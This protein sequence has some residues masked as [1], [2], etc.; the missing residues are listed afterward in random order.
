ME[1]TIQTITQMRTEIE[2]TAQV[3]QHLELD[4]S[5]IGK[6]LDV[7]RS[8]AEQTN[9]LAL[10]AAIEAARAGEAGRGFAVV[11]DEVRTLASRTA[12]STAEIHQIIDSL[13]SGAS[14]AVTAI[15]SSQTRTEEGVTQVTKAGQHLEAITQAVNSIHTTHQ[16]IHQAVTDQ[17]SVVGRVT[18]SLGGVSQIAHSNQ[19]E[20]QR[21]E[22]ASQE[23]LQQ[24]QRLQQIITQL[25]QA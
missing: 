12:E 5:R 17:K 4:S 10:N 21:T 15:E 2:A 19:S 22:S 1:E 11:A 14:Q 25:G 16:H 6:V 23:L 20:V 8:I 13:Q 3:I 24:S 9:L 7:I 18:Q